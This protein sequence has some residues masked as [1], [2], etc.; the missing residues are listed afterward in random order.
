MAHGAEG[1]GLPF[2]KPLSRCDDCI[3]NERLITG[4]MG[5]LGD[6]GDYGVHVRAKSFPYFGPNSCQ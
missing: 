1:G 3:P 5:P 4:S 2:P 6:T